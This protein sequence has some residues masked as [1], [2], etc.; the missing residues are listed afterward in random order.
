MKR[1][2]MLFIA[3]AASALGLA[4]SYRL[5][6]T[7]RERRLER[8]GLAIY[9]TPETKAKLMALYDAELARWPVPYESLMVPTRYGDTHVIA[10]GDRNASPLVLLHVAGGNATM[11]LANIAEL[12]HHYRV[13][14]LDTIGDL[15]KSVVRGA[16]PKD[17]GEYGLWLTD[18]LDELHIAKADVVGA[19][20]GGWIAHGL[21]LFAPERV[22]RLVL[23]AP[24]AG[25]PPRTRWA[26]ML[27]SL[28]LPL[29]ESYK[30]KV[31]GQ[32]LGR[33]TANSE[34]WMSYLLAASTCRPKLSPPAKF[35]DEQLRQTK[36]P[37]LFLVGDEEVVY[38]SIE[39]TLARARRFL[40][41]VHAE[42][43]A[44]AG[45]LL[46]VDQPVLVNA[47]ILHFL[48]GVRLEP[49]AA[50]TTPATISG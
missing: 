40:P 29:P 10:S 33:G 7:K 6:Q 45:H 1:T 50:D 8:E 38:A 42:V 5:V 46:N 26:K 19:S 39:E 2:G 13:Y 28:M 34:R 36:A 24:A 37:T 16:H 20:M 11:W 23:L 12:S 48:E 25:I 47:R 49:I 41:D 35:S 18:I 31:I 43:I 32:L 9:R 3:T 4:A 15:G 30:R 27:L 22:N 44:G 14:A 21:A 17:A